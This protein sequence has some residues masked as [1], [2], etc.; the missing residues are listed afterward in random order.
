MFRTVC[1]SVTKYLHLH[2]YGRIYRTPELIWRAIAQFDCWPLCAYCGRNWVQYGRAVLGMD[3][4]D[5]IHGWTWNMDFNFDTFAWI[6]T[7][8]RSISM[9][10]SYTPLTMWKGFLIHEEDWT[11]ELQIMHTDEVFLNSKKNQKHFICL[12]Q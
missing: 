7:M 4:M 9:G 10:R 2:L 8:D 5:K 3:W 11:V 12:S 1:V 6:E